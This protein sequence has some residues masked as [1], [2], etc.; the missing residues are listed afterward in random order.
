MLRTERERESCPEWCL[1]EALIIWHRRLLM[2]PV[3]YTG[4]FSSSCS[5]PHVP[6]HPLC[7]SFCSTHPPSL[8][9]I[10]F[11]SSFSLKNSPLFALFTLWSLLFLISLMSRHFPLHW[12]DVFCSEWKSAL[13]LLPWSESVYCICTVRDKGMGGVYFVVLEVSLSKTYFIWT[14]IWNIAKHPNTHTHT[15]SF[16]VLVRTFHWHNYCTL[17]SLCI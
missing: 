3:L 6:Q 5:L 16:Y 12:A 4:P 1:Q 17:L 2:S 7:S 9:Y 8:L 10:P 11:C 13:P 14:I 15:H